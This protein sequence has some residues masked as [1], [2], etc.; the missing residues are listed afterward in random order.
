MCGIFSIFNTR[1]I[2][3]KQMNFIQDIFKYGDGR[4]PD[5]HQFR[6]IKDDILFGFHRLAI[7]GLEHDSDQPIQVNDCVLI[8]N[9]EIYNYKELYSYLE[10][11][12]KTHSDCEVIIHLYKKFG[13][14]QTLQM[15]D[16]VFAFVLYDT[17]SEK[18]FVARDRFGVRPLF[19]GHGIDE[20]GNKTIHYTSTMNMIAPLNDVSCGIRIHKIEQ[21][22]PGTYTVLK[23]DSSVDYTPWRIQCRQTYYSIFT[24]HEKKPI[25]YTDDSNGTDNNMIPFYCKQIRNTLIDAVRKRVETTERPI[26]CLLSGG[27]DSSLITSIV[28]RLYSNESRTL[29]TFSIG[30]PGSVDLQF[31]KK[32]AEFLGT[33][34]TQIEI[35]E[36]EFLS[37][38]PHV[39]KTI[40]SYDTTT[41]RASVGNYLV[42]KYIAEHTN[43]KVIFNGDGSDE[44][45]GG[46]MYFHA[47]PDKFSFDYE[48]K[49][50]LNDIYYFDVL[51]SDRSISANGLEARTPFLDRDFVET[52]LSIPSHM[53]FNTHKKHCE[54]YLLRKAFDDGTYL[55]VSVLWRTKE[56][57]SDGVSGHSR[58]W[59]QIIQEYL[60]T[61]Q[62]KMAS[63]LEYTHNKPLT[64]EQM[65]YRNIF[66]IHYSDLFDNVIPY[67]WMPRFIK[68]SDASAR[69][70]SV[71]KEKVNSN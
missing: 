20:S 59:Y 38:I 30:M 51:R 63:E 17:F 70:L 45:C 41:V 11:S 44:V 23:R 62:I 46:Y 25:L 8:C 49:R 60:E 65:F 50:L 69:T 1:K 61:S 22:K 40:E 52:Y 58:S 31:A 39:I 24:I 7:N 28:H 57:F 71:Y 32:V 12:P 33:K 4:G 56:A 18:T 68:A 36:K 10:I 5:N 16:G 66:T 14:E 9:G 26:A 29:E 35:S 21:F 6:N 54:K 64:K 43:A 48:C 13:I 53:R 34:H 47:S 3:A 37:A 2:N 19:E 42:S 67:F 27:L 15:L 55:P